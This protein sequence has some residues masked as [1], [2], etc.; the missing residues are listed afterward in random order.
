[1]EVVKNQEELTPAEQQKADR[2]LMDKVRAQA[3]RY[4]EGIKILEPEVKYME[5]MTRLEKAKYEKVM[6]QFQYAQFLASQKP[7]ANENQ[8]SLSEQTSETE[9]AT[10]TSGE[11]S[12]DEASSSSL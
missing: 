7:N 8:D 5:L 10:P 12:D 3:N 9:A 4:K 1:M 2:E 11:P 6:Y